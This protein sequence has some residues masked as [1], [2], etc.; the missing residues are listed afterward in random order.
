MGDALCKCGHRKAKHTF[1][2]NRTSCRASIITNVSMGSNIHRCVCVSFSPVVGEAG[3]QRQDLG[4]DMAS[5]VVEQGQTVGGD[6][7]L[8]EASAVGSQ[9]DI[10]S[11]LGA[12][13]PLAPVDERLTWLALQIDGCIE[14]AQALTRLQDGPQLAL[15]HLRN[16]QDMRDQLGPLLHTTTEGV[17]PED[18]PVPASSDVS[19]ETRPCP[20]CEDGFKLYDARGNFHPCKTCDSEGRVALGSET[21]P[22]EKVWEWLNA[23]PDSDNPAETSRRTRIT[24]LLESLEELLGYVPWTVHRVAP[25]VVTERQEGQPVLYGPGQHPKVDYLGGSG[26]PEPVVVEPGYLG[27]HHAPAFGLYGL[28]KLP[29]DLRHPLTDENGEEIGGASAPVAEPGTPVG[30]PGRRIYL[31][32]SWRNPHQPGLVEL[33]RAAGHEVYDFR[34]PRPGDTGFAWSSIDPDWLAWHPRPFRDALGHPVAASG[35][36]S[37]FDAMEWADTFVLALPCGRSAHLEAGWA[38]GAGKP[39]A[40]LLH[41]DKFE[42]E[43]MYLMADLIA[44]DEGEVIEWL[45]ALPP[46]TDSGDATTEIATTASATPPISGFVGGSPAG[47]ERETLRELGDRLERL[48]DQAKYLD[49]VADGGTWWQFQIAAARNAFAGLLGGSVLG[50]PQTTERGENDA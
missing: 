35:F 45:D 41:E 19:S 44:V 38:I 5:S 30:A 2:D 32:S 13:S 36:K 3:P 34:N 8:W 28:I 46:A 6:Y 1:F 29:T 18:L 16:L 43:L 14:D 21:R 9:P 37:D 48:S 49:P 4:D 25:S 39:T 12:S 50:V 17:V 27:P 31:A 24:V 26:G 10:Q 40:I 42:P 20:D 33:L 7:A 11:R 47:T 22:T 15:A 23:L